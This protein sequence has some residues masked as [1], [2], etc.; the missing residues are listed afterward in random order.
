[1][2]NEACRKLTGIFHTTPITM[3]QSLLAIP[4]I[5]FQLRS[6]LH[7]Q[8]H[9]LASQPP[10]CLLRNLHKTHKVTLIPSHFPTA[11]LLPPIAEMPPFNTV[12]SYLN[13]PALPPWSHP[14]ATFHKCSKNNTPTLTL[15]KKLTGTMIFLSSVPFHIPKVYLH[16]FTIYDD[17]TL[18]ITNFC[19]A[20][21][22]THSLLLATTSSLKRVGD[23]LER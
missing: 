23:H 16:I 13:H 14:H 2:Q 18:L 6:L 7:S 4:P 10:S 19:T 1:V 15:L 9:C 17:T 21:S 22:P 3:T 8:G 11:P 12:F 20:S 5:C